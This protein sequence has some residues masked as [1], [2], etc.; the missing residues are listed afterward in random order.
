MTTPAVQPVLDGFEP[1]RDP[2]LVP[3]RPTPTAEL[4]G[5]C[6]GCAQW[7]LVDET[8]GLFK[9]HRY[10]KCDLKNRRGRCHNVGGTPE[11]MKWHEPLTKR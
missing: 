8:T 9:H 6:K 3:A 4:R 2:L 11:R 5:Q 1:R 10:H 7:P